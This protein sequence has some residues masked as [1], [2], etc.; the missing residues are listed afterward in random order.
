MS[1][2]E[3]TFPCDEC[4]GVRFLM[5]E[6]KDTINFICQS[7]NQVKVKIKAKEYKKLKKHCDCIDKSYKLKVTKDQGKIRIKQVLCGE[8]NGEVG[9][10]AINAEGNE[11]TEEEREHL[12]NLVKCEQ[13]G[14]SSFVIDINYGIPRINCKECSSFIQNIECGDYT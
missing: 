6:D 13:C 14:C 5:K 8:C 2:L 12:L 11:I 4:Y 10:I 9:W 1:E 3:T 7:C